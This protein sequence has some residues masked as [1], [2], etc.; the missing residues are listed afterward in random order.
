[1]RQQEGGWASTTQIDF[2]K[3]RLERLGY[4][5]NVNVET[6][7]VPGTE[8]QIDVEFTKDVSLASVQAPSSLASRRKGLQQS[9]ANSQQVLA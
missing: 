7:A 5:K 6:P 9:T 8:N 3:I 4:F 2:S 1:M